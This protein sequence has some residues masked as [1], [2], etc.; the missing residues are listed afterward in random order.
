MWEKLAI[1]GN[2]VC[3]MANLGEMTKL[4]ELAYLQE[5]AQLWVLHILY[6]DLYKS[7]FSNFPIEGLS[8]TNLSLAHI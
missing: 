1:L 4:W 8:I 6:A 5:S 3:F 7:L 2:G